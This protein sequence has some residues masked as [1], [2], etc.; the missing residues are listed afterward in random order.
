MEK[1]LIKDGWRKPVVIFKK[2]CVICRQTFPTG[3]P[4]RVTCGH[5][6][7]QRYKIKG[8]KWKSQPFRAIL[9]ELERLSKEELCDFTIKRKKRERERA[10]K[11][12]YRELL[13]LSE[14]TESGL[15]PPSFVYPPHTLPFPKQAKTGEIRANNGQKAGLAETTG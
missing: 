15:K 9:R 14:A 8:S 6:C 3:G 10:Q 12:M 7:R 13:I 4:S 1:I 5:H 11:L 2:K